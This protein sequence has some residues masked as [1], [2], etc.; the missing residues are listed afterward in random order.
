MQLALHIV[1]PATGANTVK[2]PSQGR[3][4]RV[5]M[6]VFLEYLEPIARG[7]PCVDR[8]SPGDAMTGRTYVDGHIFHGHDVTTPENLFPAFHKEGY[9]VEF[10]GFLIMAERNIM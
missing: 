1:Q 7:V 5:G 2:C 9:M 3:M 10:T 4:V 6:S 8:L